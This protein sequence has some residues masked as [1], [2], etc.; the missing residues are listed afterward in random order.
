MFNKLPS[1]KIGFFGKIRR[2]RVPLL[3]LLISIVVLCFSFGWA[4][5]LI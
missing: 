1:R 4:S 5:F 3:L 2:F